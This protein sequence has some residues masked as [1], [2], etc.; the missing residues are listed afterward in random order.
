MVTRKSLWKYCCGIVIALSALTFS[1]L[2]LTPGQHA[3]ELLGL[4]RTLWMGIL[5]A[6]SLVLLTL[7]GGIVHP[8]N[9]GDDEP[10]SQRDDHC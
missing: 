8:D 3:P 9:V 10:E 1:P 5:I 4:P 6:F 7:I 2:V